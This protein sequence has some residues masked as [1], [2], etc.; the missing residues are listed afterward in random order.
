MPIALRFWQHTR[1]IVPAASGN[2]EHRDPTTDVS[3]EDP[4][5]A[6][7][8][9]HGDVPTGLFDGADGSPR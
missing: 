4:A 3:I 6:G 2:H 5:G 1:G 7:A 8:D 9:S